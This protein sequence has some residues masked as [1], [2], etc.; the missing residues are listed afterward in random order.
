MTSALILLSLLLLSCRH[1]CAQTMAAP[2]PLEVTIAYSANRTTGLTGNSFWM[3]GGKAES[4]AAFTS[5]FS[6]VAEVAGEH[7]A[8]INPAHEGLS[9]VTYLIG[10][11]YSL[12]GHSRFTPFGQFLVGGVHGFDAFFPNAS[13]SGSPPDALA[14]A[15][16]GG[17]NARLTQRL[18]LRACQVE[19]L[20]T[21]LPNDSGD[22]QNGL[23]LSA[24]IVFRF[25][26]SRRAEP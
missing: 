24:G 6:V 3:A 12:A 8:S 2:A 22:R 17:L 9:F 4:N 18:A 21:H 13:T 26:G 15:A 19:Y 1:A 7:A 10:P 5:K 20:Q 14:L 16:G 23:R 25:W 11:R